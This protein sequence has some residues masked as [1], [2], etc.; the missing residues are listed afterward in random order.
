MKWDTTKRVAS[1][2][3]V[4]AAISII[5]QLDSIEFDYS[6]LSASMWISMILKAMLPGLVSI[7]ALFDDTLIKPQD[8]T[9]T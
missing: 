6:K 8:T 9:N 1:Y 3:I 7:K 5:G 2:V 4:T